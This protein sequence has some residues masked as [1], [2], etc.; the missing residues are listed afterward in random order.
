M[1]LSIRLGRIFGIPLSVN[2]TWL[3][4]FV[5]VTFT[6]GR[7]YADFYSWPSYISWTVALG[8]SLLFFASVVAHELSHSLVAIRKGIPVKGITLFIFGGVAHISREAEK[9]WAEFA[10]A[11]VGP[12]ASALIGLAFWGLY[13]VL[14]GISEQLGAMAL[15]LASVNISLGV[16]N[17]VPGFPL[18][19][20]RVL[21]AILWGVTGD[22]FRATGIST[23]LGQGMALLFIAGGVMVAVV[24][25]EV[26]QGVWLSL[27]GWFLLMAAS[28]SRRQ[29]RLRGSLRGL[30]ARHLVNAGAIIAP[31]G[32]TV[33]ELVAR[34]PFLSEQ[35]SIVITGGGQ[36]LGIVTME[37]VR[38]VPRERWAFTEAEA[39]MLPMHRVARVSADED[40]FRVLELLEESRAE[41]LAVVE[42]ELLLGM[43]RRDGLMRFVYSRNHR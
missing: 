3:A 27:I 38:H 15:V 1:N 25:R 41:E 26:L 39:I 29:L 20:G 8:T 10:M 4:V 24:V 12:F 40:A 17:M 14:E 31:S 2:I 28:A 13:Q 16:F 36:L 5:L 7:F 9:P 6:L 35:Q 30:A 37:R 11:V 32:T 42:G 18:D 43:I 22:Y 19:G 23:R 21:R 33:G 34:Y